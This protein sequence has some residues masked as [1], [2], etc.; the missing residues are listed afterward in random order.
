MSFDLP[1]NV[2]F[3]VDDVYK[4][5]SH[6]HGNWTTCPDGLSDDIKLY[7]CVS[8]LDDCILL[9]IHFDRFT[10]WFNTLGLSPN[11]SKCK[12]MTYTRIRSPVKYAY[13]LGP[14]AIA[15]S[16]GSVTNLTCYKRFLFLCRCLRFDDRE[17]R[18]E[19]RVIDELAPI[20]TTFD[21]FLKNINQNYNLSEYTTIDEMLHPFRG[22]CQWIQYIPSK[23]AKYG[24]KMFAL[25][26][27]K[28]FY[29][30]KIEIYVGKQ[31]PGSY[32]VSNSPIDI[33]K[34]LVTPIENSNRN[35]TTDNWYTKFLPDKKKE[36]GS[37]V[38]GFQK[39]KTLVSYVPRKNKAVILLSTMHHDSK[40]D[41]ETRKPE[42]IMDYNCTKGGVD[43]VDK[44]CAAY[45]VSR[46]TKRWPL[47]IFYSLMNIA[48]IN[49]QVLFS[50][51]KHNNAPK[52]R[53]LFLKTLAFDL[54]KEHLASR[55]QIS[56][57]PSDISS[58]LKIKYAVPS[59]SDVSTTPRSKRGTCFECG[60]KKNAATSMKCTK[61]MR[62]ICKL[63]SK[64]IIICEKCSNN[65]DN[66][67]SK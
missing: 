55:A 7:S 29:T 2:N 24:I 21:L 34:R 32:E 26:D 19:R 40:I 9:Q 23:P 61:C 38:F 37:S 42:I 8:S 46:I 41:V 13:H 50:Y 43:T 6:L 27:A 59:T 5:L 1:N 51:F 4:K 49:A 48:G 17:T 65:D 58:F 63:H 22:R 60:R 36:V 53:R 57:L 45:S 25:C 52:I 31:P 14:T 47:V 54:M 16:N 30:S 44:M 39:N 64:K 10:E 62:F 15:C 67:N 35:L 3:T 56:S 20:R 12:T 18:A 11:V 33:V 66:D 28:T